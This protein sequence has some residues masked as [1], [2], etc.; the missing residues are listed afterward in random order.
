MFSDHVYAINFVLQLDTSAF[1]CLI[2][3]EIKLLTPNN[4]MEPEDVSVRP[5]L[6]VSA[7]R[8]LHN[9]AAQRLPTYYRCRCTWQ[10]LR[11]SCYKLLCYN[12]TGCPFVTMA[13]KSVFLCV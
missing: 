7:L 3:C 4:L 6:S 5:T 8:C 11:L 10:Y 13:A 12:I 1:L 9:G 2:I